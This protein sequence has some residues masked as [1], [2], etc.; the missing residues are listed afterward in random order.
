MVDYHSKPRG[1]KMGAALR[2]TYDGG[3]S[4]T[5]HDQQ[6]NFGTCAPEEYTFDTAE[7]FSL[8]SQKIYATSALC[9]CRTSH[10]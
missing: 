3:R 4:S 1:L 10:A 9:M 6:R 7:S 2:R 5:A 8:A